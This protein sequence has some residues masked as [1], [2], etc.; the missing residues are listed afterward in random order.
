M[1]LRRDP[2]T[3][4]ALLAPPGH[5]QADALAERLEAGAP[6]RTVRLPLRLDATTAFTMDRDTIRLDGTLLDACDTVFL[7]G[8]G[9][10][11][12]VVPGEA[13]HTDWSV[14]QTG[15]IAERQRWSILAAALLDLARRGV[16]VV[17]PPEALRTVDSRPAC[18]ARLRR[19]GVDVPDTLA[20]NDPD[21]A[22]RFLSRRRAVW[23]PVAG[24][25]AWQ[26]FGPRQ[27]AALIDPARPPVLLARIR[28]GS[29]RRAYVYGGR[30]LAA[31][32]MEAPELDPRERLEKFWPV[33]AAP[34]HA[35]MSR[36]LSMLGLDWAVVSYV[37]RDGTPCIYDVD[38][39]PV[40]D[41]LP[42]A[43]REPLL[44]ALAA[45]LLGNRPRPRRASRTREEREGPFLRRMLRILFQFEE[46]KKR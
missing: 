20:T 10:E 19:G 28:R 43:H 29:F 22:A 33:S 39:D 36:V 1:S 4:L 13:L 9:W 16:R 17:N 35:P 44:D 12:P 7:C 26:Q 45:S 23:R 6:G 5:A 8:F 37:W 3:S 27:R 25:A 40:T 14:W 21:E 24:R 11:D 31:F 46:S 41:W 2:M 32:A 34:L 38:P 42:P 15:Y 18:L 30:V